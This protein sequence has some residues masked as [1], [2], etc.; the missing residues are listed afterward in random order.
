M[1][2]PTGTP[3]REAILDNIVSTLEAIAAPSYHTTVSAVHRLRGLN[4]LSLTAFPA[5]MV[6]TPRAD[7]DDTTHGLQIGSMH[8]TLRL[9]L[10]GGADGQEQLSWFLDDVKVALLADYTRGGVARDTQITGDEAYQSDEATNVFGAD[11]FV[12]V[13]FAHLYTDPNTPF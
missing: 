7:W 13:K 10:Q 6:S 12:N 8:L 11:I 4:A 2:Y 5:I 3:V 1:A 9:A